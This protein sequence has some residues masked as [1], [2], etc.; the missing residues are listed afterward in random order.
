MKSSSSKYFSQLDHLRLLAA[1]MVLLWHGLRYFQQVPT[2][3]VPAFW[4]LS[5]AQEGHTGVALFM[6]L[7]G[8]IFQTLCRGGEVDYFEFIRNRILRIAPLFIFWTL[9]YFYTTDV[10]PAKLFIAIASLLNK[11]AVPGVGWT[12]IVEFQFYL[13]F[14]FLLLFTRKYGLRYLAGLV[15]LAAFFRWSIWYTVGTVQDLA[16]ATIFGR[17]DQFLLGMIGCELASR[18][19]QLFHSRILLVALIVAWVSI[20]HVFDSLGGYFD[21]VNGYPSSTSVWVY[22]P[23][24]EGGFYALITA[25]YL[26]AGKLLPQS[27]DKPLAWLGSL[28][29]SFY[30]NHYITIQISYKLFKWAGVETAGFWN[31]LVFVILGAFPLMVF[32]SVITYYLIERPFL[33][34]RKPYLKPLADA[35]K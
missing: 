35:L 2:A 28:S 21:N 26:G 25:S 19:K 8:F 20:F 16:Y 22:W 13:L 29:Y 23:S 14:P 33:L 1:L 27:I 17:I 30:L 4:P 15:L 10:D 24:L 6:V 3:E 31:A 7:S 18:H 32:V 12:I 9:L 34:L 5:F 11:G